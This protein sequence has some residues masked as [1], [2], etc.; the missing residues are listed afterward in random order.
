MALFTKATLEDS[1]AT[2]MLPMEAGDVLATH[3]DIADLRQTV[4]FATNTPKKAWKS[5]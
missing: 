4:G 2:N 5:S 1:A 3:A